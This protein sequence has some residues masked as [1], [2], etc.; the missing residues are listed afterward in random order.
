MNESILIIYIILVLETGIELPGK[1]KRKKKKTVLI[2][3]HS[4]PPCVPIT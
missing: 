2:S 1:K 3:V 4:L